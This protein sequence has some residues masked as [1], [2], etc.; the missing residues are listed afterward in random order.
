[1]QQQRYWSEEDIKAALAGNFTVIDRISNEVRTK[2]VPL[3]FRPDHFPPTK[4]PR[5]K[6]NARRTR[7]MWSPADDRELLRMRG[8]GWSKLRCSHELGVTEEAA[9]K[10]IVALRGLGFAP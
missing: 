2:K 9:R 10:R 5:E 3:N 8:L 4:P 6:G 7:H 1:M